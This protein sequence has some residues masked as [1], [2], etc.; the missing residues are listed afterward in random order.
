MVAAAAVAAFEKVVVEHL[1][2]AHVADVG[3]AGGHKLSTNQHLVQHL[4]VA[5]VDVRVGHVEPQR[6][7]ALHIP[8]TEQCVDARATVIGR[9]R[10]GSNELGGDTVWAVIEVA[11]HD[12]WQSGAVQQL[13]YFQAQGQR[14]TGAHDQRTH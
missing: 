2:A 8:G 4:R 10:R 14:L 3:T 11:H 6:G 12:Q 13:D 1:H 9:L 7:L 5:L